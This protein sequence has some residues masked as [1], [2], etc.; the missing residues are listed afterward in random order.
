MLRLRGLS[1][2]RVGAFLAKGNSV[3]KPIMFRFYPLVDC[4]YSR[5]PRSH[6][7]KKSHVQVV[8]HDGSMGLVSLTT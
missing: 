6:E 1:V 7:S 8:S 2:G 3:W 4:Q 5:D